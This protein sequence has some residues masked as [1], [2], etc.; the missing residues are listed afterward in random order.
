MIHEP[1]NAFARASYNSRHYQRESSWNGDGTNIFRGSKEGILMTSSPERCCLEKT[2]LRFFCDEY[3]MR[4]CGSSRGPVGI[5]I[6][7]CFRAIGS[8]KDGKA[9]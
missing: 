8:L 5:A 2:K 7:E 4:C 9:P 1:D 3:R 6:C